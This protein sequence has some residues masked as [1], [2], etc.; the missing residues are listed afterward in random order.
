MPRRYF[1]ADGVEYR[2]LDATMRAGELIVA[3]PPVAWATSRVFRPREGH[4]RLYRL[5]EPS[6]RLTD[7]ATLARQLAAA[8]Y[9]LS[10]SGSGRE[11]VDPR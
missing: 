8:E 7:D 6:D 1:T 3:D 4:R 5:R 9:L 11:H 10:S 2:V